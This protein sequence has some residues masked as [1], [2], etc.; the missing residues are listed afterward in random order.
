MRKKI[1]LRKATRNPR[2][3]KRIKMWKSKKAWRKARWTNLWE[4][5]QKLWRSPRQIRRKWGQQKLTALMGH[6]CC[7]VLDSLHSPAQSTYCKYGNYQ[8]TAVAA[9]VTKYHSTYILGSTMRI[10]LFCTLVTIYT[11]WFW[12]PL[13]RKVS[14]DLFSTLILILAKH[15]SH[16]KNL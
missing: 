2:K 1:N 12:I 7:C 13:A 4:A 5:D 16:P 15:P 9:P 6:S 8:R 14:H 3:M 11:R 10:N